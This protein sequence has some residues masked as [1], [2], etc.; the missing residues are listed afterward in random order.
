MYKYKG[1]AG[2]LDHTNHKKTG[3]ILVILNLKEGEL[4]VHE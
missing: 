3:D 1:E 2:E 4:R